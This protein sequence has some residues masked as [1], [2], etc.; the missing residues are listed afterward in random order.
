MII[1]GFGLWFMATMEIDTADVQVAGALVS[2]AEVELSIGDCSFVEEESGRHLMVSVDAKNTGSVDVHLKPR[3]FR[4]IL[5]R[6]GAPT[7]V[8]VQRNIYYPMRFTSSCDE[9]LASISRIPPDCER[10]ISL[11]F[12]GGNLPQGDEWDEYYLSLEYYD[13]ATPIMLSRTLNPQK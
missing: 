9:A 10:H 4:L 1:L 6:S 7:L 2:S 13:P 8:A 11:K 5:I 12:W 3:E